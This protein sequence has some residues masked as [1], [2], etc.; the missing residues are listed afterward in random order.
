MKTSLAIGMA[1][2]AGVALAQTPANR[3]E[4]M[5]ITPV[6]PAKARAPAAVESEKNARDEE[7]QRAFAFAS[8]VR[9]KMNDPKSFELVNAL[10]TAKGGV[11]IRFRG[12]NAYNATVTQE[13]SISGA[14]KLTTK[15][16]ACPA[17]HKPRDVTY[18]KAML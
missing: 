8:L 6:D 18:I 14:D 12:K 2:L 11:C 16:A 3:W 17:A 15:A 9:E 4:K 5:G 10:V 13:A 7:T 1:L